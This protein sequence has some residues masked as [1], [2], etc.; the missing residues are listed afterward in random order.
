MIPAT[1]G[2]NRRVIA[3]LAIIVAALALRFMAFG[4]PRPHEDE[5][6]YLYVGH[7][8]AGGAW[9]Y[10]D[11]WDRKPAGLFFIYALPGLLPHPA[12]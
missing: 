12:A 7:A 4:H 11:I 8:M 5:H 2:D 6:F 1:T 9:P 3:V 10:A